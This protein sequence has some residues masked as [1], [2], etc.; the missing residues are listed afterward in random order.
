MRFD[1]FNHTKP[2]SDPSFDETSMEVEQQDWRSLGRASNMEKQSF[3]LV[4]SLEVA[5]GPCILCK[6]IDF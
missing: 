5:S 4:V 2:H 3:P 1:P 6:L